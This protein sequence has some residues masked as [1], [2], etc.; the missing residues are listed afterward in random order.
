M[1]GAF[2]RSRRR[3][4]GY[5][6]GYLLGV[7]LSGCGSAAGAGLRAVDSPWDPPRGPSDGLRDP[8]GEEPACILVTLRN[9]VTLRSCSASWLHVPSLHPI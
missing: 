3:A 1:L 5:R 8:S 9:L 4:R 7:A 6:Q 2:E